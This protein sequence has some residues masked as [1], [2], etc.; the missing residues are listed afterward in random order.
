MIDHIGAALPG[1]SEQLLPITQQGGFEE[2]N[3]DRG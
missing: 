3:I 1:D 2:N